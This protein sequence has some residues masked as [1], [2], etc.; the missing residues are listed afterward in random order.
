LPRNVRKIYRNAHN[1]DNI[2][3]LFIKL[4]PRNKAK[5]DQLK[6]LHYAFWL[7]NRREITLMGVFSKDDSSVRRVK[8]GISCG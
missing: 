6:S 5:I 2:T 4:D 8:Q 3:L 7:R 1:N